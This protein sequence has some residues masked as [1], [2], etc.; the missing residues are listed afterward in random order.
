MLP[1]IP[2]TLAV[3]IGLMAVYSGAVAVAVAALIYVG[4]V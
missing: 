3:A 4:S 2:A 1:D